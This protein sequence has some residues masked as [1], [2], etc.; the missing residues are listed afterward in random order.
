MPRYFFNIYHDRVTRDDLGTELPDRH[1]AW[2]EATTAA[3]EIIRG[4]DGSLKPD[5]DWRL[6]VTDEFANPLWEIHVKALPKSTGS[7]DN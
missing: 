2:E 4:I 6:E 5:R 3:G 7:I 1:A